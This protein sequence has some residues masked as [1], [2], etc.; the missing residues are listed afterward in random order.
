[1]N[2]KITIKVNSTFKYLQLWNGVFNLTDMELRVLAAL[3]D[4]NQITEDKN[5]CTSKNK[6]AAASSLGIK[7]F[8]SLNIYVKKFMDKGAIRNDGKKYVL[9]QLLMFSYFSQKLFP[10]HKI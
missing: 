6:K 8:N 10:F 3:V 1:M 2:Q 7:D 9:N 4:C 5:L